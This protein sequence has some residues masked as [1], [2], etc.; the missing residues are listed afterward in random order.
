MKTI[1]I[2]H[3]GVL[4]SLRPVPAIGTVGKLTL[5]IEGEPSSFDGI[6]KR[7]AR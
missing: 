2:S 5:I 6:M 3:H 4:F 7:H 1:N